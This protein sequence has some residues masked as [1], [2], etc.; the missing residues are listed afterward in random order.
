VSDLKAIR[1]PKFDLRGAAQR[2]SPSCWSS[3][4]GALI[5]ILRYAICL[6]IPCWVYWRLSIPMLESVLGYDEQEFVWTGWSVLKRMVPYK[7]FVEWKPPMAFLSHA[8]ALKLFGFHDFHFRYFFGLLS[9]GSICAVLASLLRRSSDLVVCSALGL[10]MVHLFLY[11]GFHETYVADTESIGLAY[12]Y[13][14][15]AALIAVTRYRRAAEI[16]GGILFTWSVLSKEPFA[17]CVLPTWAGCYFVVHPRFST[18]TARDYLKYTTI[19][20]AI[21]VGALCLYMAPT[22]A[23]SAYVALA[24]RYAAIFRDPQNGYCVVLGTFKPT[25]KFWVDLPAQ[26]ARLENDFFNLTTLSWLA[27]F[28][29]ATLAFA[30]RR[31]WPSLLCAMAAVAGALYGVTTTHC[32]FPHYYVMG[33][34]GVVFFL[35]VGVDALGRRLSRVQ[36]SVRFWARS[37]FFLAAA[38]PLWPRVDALTGQ[39]LK[40]PPPYPDPVPGA[41]DFIRHNSTANDRIF[42]TGPAGLYVAVDRRPGNN[43]SQVFDEL[44]PGMPGKTDAEKLRPL[45]DQLVRGRPKIVFLDPELSGTTRVSASR[46]RRIM[47]GA[48]TPFLTDYK[49]VKA[50]E[51]FYLRP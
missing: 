12:Y 3:A 42:T 22:G 31:S 21:A 7:D 10:A 27:P 4:G 49:Y 14:G 32:Y 8:L 16:A 47:A 39:T 34:S 1:W 25:G 33:E 15:I 28:F 41:M 48:I 20:V 38:V 45:Y 17:F 46:K 29:A 30:P 5:G 40:E 35:I 43:W 19:G 24:R 2:L 23:L 36:P 37:I 50:S 51:Y 11:P 13:F 18:S 26:W 44:L 6:A 9:I